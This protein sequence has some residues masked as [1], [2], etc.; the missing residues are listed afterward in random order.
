MKIALVASGNQQLGVEYLSASLKK[1]GYDVRLFF[2]PMT[3]GGSLFVKV[4]FVNK[5][6]NLKDKIIE[7]I[8]SFNPDI[9][10]FSAMTHNYQWSLSIANE[11][12][13]RANIPIIFGGIHPTSV[14]EI[15]L[16][17]ESIDLVAVGEA[18]ESFVEVISELEA[19]KTLETINKKINGIYFKENGK[20]I[21]NPPAM[22]GNLD[23][24]PYPDKDLYY[25]K[26]P[27][28]SNSY[29]VSASRGCPNSC[30]Y[31]CNSY[32]NKV[33]SKIERRRVRSVDNIIDELKIAKKKYNYSLIDF[34]DEIFPDSISWLEEFSEKYRNEIGI[35]FGISLDAGRDFELITDDRLKLLKHAGCTDVGFGLTSG[36]EKVRKLMGTKSFS[37]KKFI[38]ILKMCKSHNFTFATDIIIGTPNETDEDLVKNLDFCRTIAPY[39]EFTYTYWLTYFPKTFVTNK[40]LRHNQISEIAH[41]DILEGKGDIH[42]HKGSAVKDRQKLLTYRL[43]VDL[44]TLVSTKNHIWIEKHQYI[45]NIFPFKTLL[46]WFFIFLNMSKNKTPNSNLYLLIFRN[47]FTKRNCP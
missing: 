22:V 17:Q 25:D 27:S 10:G 7:K 42:I 34:T 35:P 43:L 36:S 15:V 31:C 2:D 28:L 18:E 6:F 32:L 33:Y 38:E 5:R 11:I 46:H 19:G 8:I 12:K 40:A 47:F 39:I 29:S 9:I 45:L 23:S 44:S 4:N 21:E 3:F 30:G 20:I 16:K 14:P 13:K 24:L 37:N 41:N 1:Q 26:I